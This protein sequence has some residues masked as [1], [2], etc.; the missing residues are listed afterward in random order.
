MDKNFSEFWFHNIKGYR[1]LDD[2]RPE[3][4]YGDKLRYALELLGISQVEFSRMTGIAES[5]ISRYVNGSR[6]PDT[7]NAIRMLV[8]LLK[9]IA[10]RKYGGRIP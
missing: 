10:D 2:L 4:L 9:V 7:R 6:I 5:T 3:D 8:V 1:S